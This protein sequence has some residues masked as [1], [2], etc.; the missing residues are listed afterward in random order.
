[1]VVAGCV[2]RVILLEKI[3]VLVEDVDVGD[4]GEEEEEVVELDRV[5]VT[6]DVDVT[7]E[8]DVAMTRGGAT[9]PMPCE[10][11]ICMRAG[12]ELDVEVVTDV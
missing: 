12:E 6:I 7:I 1:M 2:G 10:V 11:L 4:S 5:E 3:C 8:V 9:A